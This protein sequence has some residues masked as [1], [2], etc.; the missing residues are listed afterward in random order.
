MNKPD[1]KSILKD[2]PGVISVDRL[3]CRKNLIYTVGLR[4]HRLGSVT[5][6]RIKAT[7]V[8]ALWDFYFRGLSGESRNFWPPYPLFSPSPDSAEELKKRILDWKKESDWIYIEDFIDAVMLAAEKADSFNPLN[9]GLGEGHTIEEAL[10]I[11][12]EVDGYTNARIV[13]NASKPSMIP[14][15]LIDTTKAKDVLGFK[16]RTGLREGISKTIRWYRKTYHITKK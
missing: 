6:K 5:I 10:Q 11:M 2:I 7:D 9:I 4:Y 15:R 1:L 3:V 8:A 12:L 13:T 16:A 14:V